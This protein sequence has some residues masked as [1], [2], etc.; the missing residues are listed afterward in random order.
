MVVASNVNSRRADQLN[1]GL[2]EPRKRAAS[3][4]RFS[5]DLQSERSNLAQQRKCRNRAVQDGLFIETELEFSD[6]AISGAKHQRVGF[7][8]MMT[9]ARAGEFQVLYIEDLSR[10]DRDC[11]L[12]NTPSAFK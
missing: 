11:V 3:Y 10:L 2:G 9:A 5:S 8:A 1:E 4:S 7:Q 12:Q 6:E